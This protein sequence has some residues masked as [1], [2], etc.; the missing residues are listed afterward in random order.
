M[1]VPLTRRTNAQIKEPSSSENK[2]NNT[3]KGKAKNQ[4]QKV[5]NKNAEKVNTMPAG[6]VDL[7][8]SREH[9]LSF[10]Q[11]KYLFRLF[12]LQSALCAFPGFGSTMTGEL[13]IHIDHVREYWLF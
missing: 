5:N 4:S 12:Q 6:C 2:M 3:V 7:P 8:P 9:C 1:D 13:E 10:F 11:I